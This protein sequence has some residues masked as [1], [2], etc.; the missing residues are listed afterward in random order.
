VQVVVVRCGA[1]GLGPTHQCRSRGGPGVHVRG[2]Q[3]DRTRH[4]GEQEVEAKGEGQGNRLQGWEG[5]VIRQ[6]STTS[7]VRKTARVSEG[8]NVNV[9]VNVFSLG[10]SN[11]TEEQQVYSAIWDMPM[12]QGVCTSTGCS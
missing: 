12:L 6:A 11:A 3:Q 10:L 7:V 4:H 2:E 9:N 5:G 8:V 1:W